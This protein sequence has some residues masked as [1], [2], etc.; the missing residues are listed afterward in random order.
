[1]RKLVLCLGVL[2]LA[3]VLAPA[4]A[5][6]VASGS[7]STWTPA[8]HDAGASSP[9]HPKL[10]TGTLHDPDG[11]D[12]RSFNGASSEAPGASEGTSLITVEGDDEAAVRDAVEA[13]GGDVLVS[14]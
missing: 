5:V 12:P 3:A 13:A 14:R 4:P 11:S 6:A 1:M 2:A 10:E 9:D 8:T 7:G